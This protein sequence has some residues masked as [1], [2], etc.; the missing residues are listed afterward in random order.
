VFKDALNMDLTVITAQLT[1]AGKVPGMETLIELSG[2]SRA[3]ADTATEE[4]AR[5]VVAT[6]SGR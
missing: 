6:V 2:Q 4:R 5:K 1:L 3:D